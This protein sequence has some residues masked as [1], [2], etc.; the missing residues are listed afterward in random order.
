MRRC[1][2][3]SVP[4][5]APASSESRVREM[6]R[7]WLTMM[8]SVSRAGGTTTQNTSRHVNAVVSQPDS[9]APISDG[10]TQAAE[11]HAKTLGRSPVG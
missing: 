3:R 10:S 11:I 8:P 9:G 5:P 2:A 7:R 4:S 1:E 6:A